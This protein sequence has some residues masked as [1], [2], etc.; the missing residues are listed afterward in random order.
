MRGSLDAASAGRS[1]MRAEA[2]DFAHKL[3]HA[4]AT[5][6][7]WL[8][9]KADEAAARLLRLKTAA[10]EVAH[11]QSEQASLMA[12]RV[13]AQA[14]GEL[15][16]LRR[17]ARAGDLKPAAWRKFMA[18]GLKLKREPREPIDGHAPSA[19]ELDGIQHGSRAPSNALICVEP[20]R[21][22][23]PVVQTKSHSA[24]FAPHG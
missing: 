24:Q 4:R 10:R 13:S 11:H 22:R 5:A 1:W 8:H 17:A 18:T 7:P 21:C 14:K 16:A 23:L 12:L 15:D 6:S 9:T 19:T 20:W 3:H 2:S